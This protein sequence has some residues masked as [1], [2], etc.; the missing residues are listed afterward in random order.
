M[1]EGCGSVIY[2]VYGAA[3]MYH[4]GW[5]KCRWVGRCVIF[6]YNIFKIVI[7]LKRQIFQFSLGS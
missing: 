6:F 3:V 4:V 2:L 7:N 5:G 1:G